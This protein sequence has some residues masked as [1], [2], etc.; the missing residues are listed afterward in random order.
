MSDCMYDTSSSQC[1]SFLKLHLSRRAS[2][3]LLL[4]PQHPLK[5]YRMQLHLMLAFNNAAASRFS[6]S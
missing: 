2:M 3:E 5:A 4:Y 1:A 6:T